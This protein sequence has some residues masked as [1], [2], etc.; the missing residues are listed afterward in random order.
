M[1]RTAPPPG[2]IKRSLA[3]ALAS[4][5][6]FGGLA[7]APVAAQAAGGE[8]SVSDATFLW[9]INGESNG[10][11]YFGGCNFLSAGT[12]GD[13]G[14][15]RV[16]N[17]NDDFYATSE[18]NVTIE[19]PDA[20]GDYA[21]PA[22][23][24]KCQNRNGVSVN[25]K[26][27]NAPD[28]V[29]ETRVRIENGTG[30]ANPE[31][32]TAS[33]SWDGSF[34]VAY[35]GGMTYWSATDPQL[36]VN[37][38]G[39]GTVTADLSGY[40]TDMDDM[41]LWVPIE[42]RPV[43]LA[44]L[45]DVEVTE[46]GFVVTPDYLGVVFEDGGQGRNPQAIKTETNSPWWG[47][48][49]Q[50]FNDFHM[51]TGQ[52]SYWYT[53][54]GTAN[55]IQPRKVTSPM[56]VAYSAPSAPEAPAAP[57]VTA[58]PTGAVTATWAAPADGGSPITGYTV[59][60]TPASGEAATVT[61]EAG[62]TTATTPVLL[63]GQE[64]TVTV[65]AT[66]AKGTTAS[67]ASAAI[68]PNPNP[69]P[70]VTVTPTT[71]LDPNVA[72]TLTV[73]A[74]G[75]TGPAAVW[76]S[77]VGLFD[78]ATWTPGETP[79][80]ANEWIGSPAWVQPTA[81]VDGAFTHEFVIPAGTLQPGISYGVTTMAAHGIVFTDR[82][83][84][85]F[86]P[87]SAVFPVEKPAAP[88]AP[89]I[90]LTGDAGA[91]VT[92]AAP[93]SEGG[94]PV[95]EYRVSLTG[96]D[97]AVTT[98]RVP[99]PGTEA[100]FPGLA[101]GASYSATVAA[102][103]AGGFSPESEASASLTIPATAPDAPAAPT[104]TATGT[105]TASIAW[106]A[107]ADGGSAITG[108]TVAVRQGSATVAEVN[109][110]ADQR[111]VNVTGLT[112]G[113]DYTVAVTAA[114]AVGTSQASESA[115][116]RT[117]AEAPDALAAPSATA[118]SGTEIAV[119][120]APTS[121]DGGSAVTGYTVRA[122]AA[123]QQPVEIQ[124]PA[125]ATSA[126][127]TGLANGTEY[128]VTVSAV[129]E[130][131]ASVPSPAATATTHAVPGAPTV[132]LELLDGQAA[133]AT[134][135]VPSSGG[136][137]VTG[138]RA[139]L[140]IDGAAVATQDLGAGI[141]TAA[142]TGLTPG[143]SYT[144]QVTAS[145]AVG[146]SAAGASA[147]ITVPAVAP[148]APAAPAVTAA[149]ESGAT[150]TDAATVSW[151][152]PTS[153][154][155]AAISEYVVTL[156]PSGGEPVS[157]TVA[158][159]TLTATFASLTQGSYTATVVAR[160][161]AGDSPVSADSAALALAGPKP[162]SAPTLLGEGE[163]TEAEGRIPMSVSADGRTLTA[164]PGAEQANRWVGVS[165]H[166]EANFVGWFLTGSD[167]ALTAQLPALLGDHHAVAYAQDGTPLGS[168]AYSV[169][170]TVTEPKP[171]GGKTPVTPGVDQKA[172]GGKTA[173]TAAPLANTGGPE[174]AGFVVGG[175]VLL[176]IGGLGMARAFRRGSRVE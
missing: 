23:G 21:E 169:A 141:T 146:S 140:L 45:S 127:L 28:S 131:G 65:S 18:G 67:A 10:G 164:M 172:P 66:N 162:T 8:Q 96:P 54:D 82:R 6:A 17:T 19:K 32:G 26:T 132:S 116:L 98:Q 108:Y 16:W 72:Q 128:S 44:N 34:T 48:F 14:S 155:G 139:T 165:V 168:V 123:G 80:P 37:A 47:S 9:G 101:R 61:A 144:A 170:D 43:T 52:S 124:A 90:S 50:D 151:L 60:A 134:W 142:F 29:T 77:Y 57:T 94:A 109:A 167:G 114:N 83:L 53:T 3:L 84:D 107:P 38:D 2:G 99:A 156:A 163:L 22:W 106:A 27:T 75:F 30:T 74:T 88:A 138:Y 93:D 103:N 25:N 70:S 129:N 69:T 159:D 62:A 130:A 51:L 76:G 56:T 31:A 135:T 46:D 89:Q 7:F 63:P 143:A 158:G 36:T 40:G 49:P 68:T 153:T 91:T 78:A 117:L 148:T 154:G 173:T 120:W 160:N 42:P 64:Y 5:V 24:T 86:T 79:P 4:A 87:I 102:M 133:T 105:T 147:S 111:S 125:D 33:I 110:A 39:T 71:G 174:L 15:A 95:T 12:A 121:S 137:A 149:V 85:T 150:R 92:W 20:A 58:A 152:A 41:S 1:H 97:G 157:Q 59:T 11:A 73:T 136:S 112:R 13:S 119:A 161:S 113:T 175:L 55:S 171:D 81:V 100:T 126:T 122:T 176:L 104:A 35:Y 166:S 145:N 118:V 115:A